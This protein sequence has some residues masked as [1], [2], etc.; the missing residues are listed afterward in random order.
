M[1]LFKSK[2]YNKSY[3]TKYIQKNYI[4]IIN[5]LIR[6]NNFAYKL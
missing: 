6:L 5:I 2:D 3:K 4:V 1:I